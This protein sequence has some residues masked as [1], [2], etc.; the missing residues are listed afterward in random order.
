MWESNLIQCSDLEQSINLL[1]ACR[2]KSITYLLLPSVVGIVERVSALTP[3]YEV[4]KARLVSMN[5]PYA[6][7]ARRQALDVFYDAENG[8]VWELVILDDGPGQLYGLDTYEPR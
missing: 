3:E 7:R 2:N 5:L 1:S 4:L 8:R 6:E